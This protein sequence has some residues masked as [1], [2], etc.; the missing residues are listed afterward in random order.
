MSKNKHTPAPWRLDKDLILARDGTS[1]A[2]AHEYS[3]ANEVSA[4]ARLIAAA[5]EMLEQLEQ[6]LEHLR[7]FNEIEK[8]SAIGKM[9][10]DIQLV[11]KKAKDST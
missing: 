7:A 9:I 11:L 3:D 2:R 10:I 1:P 6:V 4:N 8:S 5:P